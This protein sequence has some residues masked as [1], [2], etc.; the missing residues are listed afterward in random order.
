MSLINDALDAA[1]KFHYTNLKI[2]TERQHFWEVIQ[3]VFY[4][5]I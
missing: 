3:N 1:Y 2:P 4:Q 5:I